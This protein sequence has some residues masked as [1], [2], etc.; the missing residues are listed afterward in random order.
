[1]DNNI[2]N[3]NDG[4]DEIIKKMIRNEVASQMNLQNEKN[5][6]EEV[7]KLKEEIDMVI[8]RE[9]KRH[10]SDACTMLINKFNA[11]F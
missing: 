7:K 9:V 11:K 6:D 3:R 4:F 1:M 10:I 2:D 8:S 5:I